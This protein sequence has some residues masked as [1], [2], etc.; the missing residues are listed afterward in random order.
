MNVDELIDA[1]MAIHPKGF[2]LSL[3]RV[4]RLLAILGDPQKKIPPTIHVA[5]TNGKGSTIAFCRAILEASGH[6]V[7][8]HTSPHLVSWHERFR[9]GNEGDGK[10]ASDAVLADA[11]SRVSEA[12][13]GE[14]ITVFEILSAV[15]FVLFS[16]H[17]ADFCLVEVGLGGRF[18]ATNVL[19]NPAACVIT[20][21]EL[22]HQSYLGNT[23]AKI[24]FEK[25]GIIKPGSRVIIGPQLDEAREIIEAKA[26]ECG[27][28][29]V[30]AGQD[31]DYYAQRSEER[32]VGK[33][34]RSRWSPYH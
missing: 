2:D 18:D 13:K 34:C 10:L 15:M 29:P 3:G 6:S 31:F 12:N 14:P 1:L 11:I 22:D 23:I 24:A 5:G 32:R 33:E 7:H 19:E 9:L 4:R 8:V 27:S 26:A 30:I 17:P 16:E 21:V 28:Q 20:P 25:A